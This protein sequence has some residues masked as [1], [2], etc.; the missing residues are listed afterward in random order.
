MR[1]TKGRELTTHSR[2]RRFTLVSLVAVIAACGAVLVG[3]APGAGA[4]SSNT[5]SV[6]AGEYAYI[7]KGKPQPGWVNIQFKNGGVEYHM[8]VVVALK[9]G[10]TAAQLKKVAISNDDAAFGKIAQG[11]GNVYGLPELLAPGQQTATYTELKAGHYGVMCF[12]TA[13]DGVP[14][15]A[16][17][18]V[19]TFDVTGSKSSAKPPQDGVVDVTMTDTSITVPSGD[20][21]QHT[22]I[23][24][25]N[26][27]TNPHNFVIVKLESGKTLDDAKAYFDAFFD[28][29]TAPAGTAPAPAGTAPATIVGGVGDITPGGIAYL[30]WNLK[31]GHY[32]YVST[33]GDLPNDD[34]SKGMKGEFDIK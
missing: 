7:L 8:M 3:V 13:P 21:P 26:A 15:V 31:S 28:S 20:A 18:M 1:R 17:G 16:H 12:I 5:L 9:K 2:A 29:G 11:D 25:T 22:T 27:G 23:K 6:T 19:K 24:V 32:G 34:Y 33:D 14:H 4:A 10:V 30:D